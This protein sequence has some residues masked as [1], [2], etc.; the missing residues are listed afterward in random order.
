MSQPPVTT[1]TYSGW[2]IVFDFSTDEFLATKGRKQRRATHLG[3]IHAAIDKADAAEKRATVRIEPC[4]FLYWDDEKSA[5]VRVEITSYSDKGLGLRPKAGGEVFM[6]P[7]GGYSGSWG[8]KDGDFLPVIQDGTDTKRLHTAVEM[9]RRAQEELRQ[10]RAAIV[11]KVRVERVTG[12]TS[13]RYSEE[14]DRLRKA[15]NW[16]NKPVAL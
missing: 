5:E 2:T 13:E 12:N 14:E 8:K 7:L 3:W 15:V 11:T 4:E 10:A 1:S 9:L 6:V 16:L